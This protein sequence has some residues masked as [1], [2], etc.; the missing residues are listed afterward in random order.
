MAIAAARAWQEGD[1]GEVLGATASFVERLADFSAVYDLD[2]FGGGHSTL[3]EVAAKQGLVYKPCGAGGGDVGVVLGDSAGCIANFTERAVNMGF[4]LLDL[5]LG[6]TDVE[7]LT[8][9]WMHD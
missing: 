1:A 5:D 7:G 6:G 3:L 9:E 4:K 2:V 8:V